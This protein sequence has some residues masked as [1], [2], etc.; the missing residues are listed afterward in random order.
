MSTT[1]PATVSS[2]GSRSI[3][4]VALAFGLAAGTLLGWP[5]AGAAQIDTERAQ[6]ALAASDRLLSAIRS[7]DANY[8]I[9]R[10]SD[11]RSA[12]LYDR[13]FDGR[14][15][16]PLSPS[17]SDLLLLKQLQDVSGS[18]I[19]ALLLPADGGQGDLSDPSLQQRAGANFQRFL[20]ELGLVYDYRVL[21][22]A[23]IAEGAVTARTR[24]A[25]AGEIEPALAALAADQ[26]Q[27]IGSV[28]ACASDA[29]IDPAWRSER[30]RLLNRTAA[31]FA[32]LLD[33]KTAQQLADRALAA[34]IRAQDRDVAAGFQSFALSLLR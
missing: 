5:V 14:L 26:A 13:A 25:R 10:L 8:P 31:Q 29:N 21:T 22:G 34:A 18:I 24:L 27:V 15:S 9:P 20:P 3:R 19:S 17:P 28:I 2:R 12:A 32:G 7:A 6:A 23:L 1:C 4:A 11:A 30:L 33:K 16:G